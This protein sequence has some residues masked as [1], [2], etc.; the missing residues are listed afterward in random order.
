VGGSELW[1]L[2][3]SARNAVENH[4]QRARIQLSIDVAVDPWIEGMIL[5]GVATEPNLLATP[6]ALATVRD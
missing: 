2:W 6:P 1:S 3:L 5:N 4:A